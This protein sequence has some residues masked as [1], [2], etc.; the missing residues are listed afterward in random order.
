MGADLDFFFRHDQGAVEQRE[1]ADCA[2]AVLADRK[3]AARVTRD[4]FADHHCARLFAAK[5]SKDLC[6]LAIKSLAKLDVR[7]D[8]LRPPVGFDVSIVLN[9]AHKFGSAATCRRFDNAD[10]SAHSER[11]VATSRW[12][13]SRC[14]KFRINA[15]AG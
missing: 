11:Q 12:K 6:A 15:A 4:M 3:R 14:I 9:V 10:M 13:F 5:L 7:R 1:I 2:L 8:R